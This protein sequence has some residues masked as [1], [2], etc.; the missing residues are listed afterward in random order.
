MTLKL[1]ILLEDAQLK[2]DIVTKVNSQILYV[3]G[4]FIWTGASD[5]Y[6]RITIMRKTYSV[7]RVVWML[8]N[9]YIPEGVCVCHTCD[10][11]LCCNP[12]HLF[13]GTDKD[14]AIDRNRKCRQARGERVG[15]SL[16]TELQVTSIRKYY[17]LGKSQKSLSEKYRVGAATI[18]Q[19]VRRET[20][21]HVVP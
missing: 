11:P 15:N 9:G 10:K 5:K 20:W 21:K 7:H 17:S 13:L 6:G 16:L 4:C 14:N 3:E 12:A 2:E 8:T 18:G 19:I 1:S